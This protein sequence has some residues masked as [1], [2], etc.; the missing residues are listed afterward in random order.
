MS[1]AKPRKRRVRGGI[2]IILARTDIAD[3]PL[4]ICL[5]IFANSDTNDTY[6]S[7]Q[8]KNLALT[9]ENAEADLS[10]N[11]LSTGEIETWRDDIQTALD[12]Y[13][14]SES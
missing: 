2:L 1:V 14:I 13:L 5:P 3:G 12:N 9:I 6:W 8:L 4:Y 11:D 10:A 7:E